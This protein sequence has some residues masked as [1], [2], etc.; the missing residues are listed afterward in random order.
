[1]LLA[2]KKVKIKPIEVGEAYRINDINFASNSYELSSRIMLVLNEF[3]DFLTTNDNLKVAINGYTDNVGDPKN[4]LEL[5]QNRAK[6]VYDYLLIEDVEASR[7]TFK[8]YGEKNPATSNK[9]EAGRKKNRRTEF[10]ILS[11]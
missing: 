10:V 9:T 5:S 2:T 1:M 7:L 4:N 8:G 11:K 6:A 3:I